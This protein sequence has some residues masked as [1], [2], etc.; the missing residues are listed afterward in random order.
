MNIYLF[1]LK[2][3]WKNTILWTLTIILLLAVFQLNIYPV[4]AGSLDAVMEM[5]SGF[6]KPVLAAFGF[7]ANTMFSFGGFFNLTYSYLSLIGAIMA[8]TLSVASFAREKRSKCMDFLH[9]KP[10]SRSKIFAAKL[11][12][13]LTL[14]CLSNLV[15]VLSA[16]II[17][18]ASGESRAGLGDFL[19]SFAGLFFT[20]LLFTA[21][22]TAFAIFAKKVRSVSG[23]AT[24]VGFSAFILTALD[25]I[26]EDTIIHYLA[27]LKYFSPTAIYSKGSYELEYVCVAILIGMISLGAAYVVYCKHDIHSV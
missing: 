1:E 22:G 14:L 5:V 16:L 10:Y 8:T 24:A 15:I 20:E 9:S 3:Q 4:F 6:P 26:I 12:E 2:A 13:L 21:I 27:A 19:L 25:A 17:Y 23:V 18:N 11:L 7:D